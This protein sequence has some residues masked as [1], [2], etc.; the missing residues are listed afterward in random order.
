MVSLFIPF[1]MSLF[2]SNVFIYLFRYGCPFVLS[3]SVLSL[4]LYF[5]FVSFDLSPVRSLCLGVFRSS[6]LSFFIYFVF[7]VLGY[8]LPFCLYF[9]SSFVFYEFR[10]FVCFFMYVVMSL[11]FVRPFFRSFVL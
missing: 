9:F 3:F 4:L 5:V 1:F 11:V 7:V 6:F 2:V 8:V 10:S